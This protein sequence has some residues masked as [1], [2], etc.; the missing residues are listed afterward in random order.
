MFKEYRNLL[1]RANELSKMLNNKQVKNKNNRMQI[2]TIV[3]NTVPTK[4][5][6]H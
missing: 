2:A 6:S 3:D 1:I 4:L 5:N